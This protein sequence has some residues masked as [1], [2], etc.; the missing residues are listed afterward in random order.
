[1]AIFSPFFLGNIGQKIVFNNIQEQK[2]NFL[3]C[4]NKKFKKWKTKLYNGHF[5][6]FFLGNIGQGNVFYDIQTHGFGPK[7]A[8]FQSLFFLGNIGQP[9][10][11]YNILRQ[12]KTNF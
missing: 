9:S 10:V 7:M 2:N 4:K 8:I 6:S 5:S 11:F 1:M 3:G 12:K